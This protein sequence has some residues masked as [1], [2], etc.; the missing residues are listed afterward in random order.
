MHIHLLTLI[1]VIASISYLPV[2]PISII[3]VGIRIWAVP[4]YMGMGISGRGGKVGG[5]LDEM[6]W[7]SLITIFIILIIAHLSAVELACITI[8]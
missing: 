2:H 1:I 7:L 6:D 8:R 3:I 4:A 5:I